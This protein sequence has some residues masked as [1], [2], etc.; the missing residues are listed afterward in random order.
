MPDALDN[1]RISVEYCQCGTAL[2]APISGAKTFEWA[3]GSNSAEQLVQL[4]TPT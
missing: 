4:S 2:G 1:W 3:R